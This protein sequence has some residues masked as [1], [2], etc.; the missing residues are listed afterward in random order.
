MSI[1]TGWFAQF[2]KG[3]IAE[4]W[5]KRSLGVPSIVTCGTRIGTR[6]A[7][8]ASAIKVV[9]HNIAEGCDSWR[10]ASRRGGK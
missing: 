4:I 9:K 8:I 10:P 2:R 1:E 6:H 7:A 5:A 3:T